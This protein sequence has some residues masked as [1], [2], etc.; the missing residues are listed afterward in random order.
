M[1]KAYRRVDWDSYP[2]NVSSMG[3]TN[4]NHLDTELDVED[5][6]MISIGFTQKDCEVGM[7]E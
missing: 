2:G 7:Y 3:D 1:N 5:N 6:R 4:M